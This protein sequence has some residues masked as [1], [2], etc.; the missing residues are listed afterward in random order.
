MKITVLSSLL[1]E[2]FMID[3]GFALDSGILV[4]QLIDHDVRKFS[5][6]ESFTLRYFIP[7]FAENDPS[8]DPDGSSTPPENQ[9]AGI[10][11]MVPLH[12]SMLK[13]GTMCSYGTTEIAEYLRMAL[14]D[15]RVIGVLLD[16]DTPGGSVNSI[17]PL[18]DVL[19]HRTKPVL[20]HVD[21]CASAGLFTSVFCD[22]IMANNDIS[23]RIGSV[24]VEMNFADMRPYWEAQKVVFHTIRPPES[25]EKN[26]VFELALEGKYEQITQEML[27]P[28]ARRFQQEVRSHLPGLKEEPGVLTGATFD[29]TRSLEL[30]LIHS[31]GNRRAAIARL[32]E[33]A[34]QYDVNSLI[35]NP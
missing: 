5:P 3:L 1:R 9:P 4:Q 22:E 26:R 12:G 20:A 19:S 32:S 6:R 24:G 28:M 10:I 15:E 21:S 31:I 34:L 29:A 13:Y 14:S 35:N 17:P 23:A 16:V 27:S 33:L 11:A 30:G 25:A 7:S 8:A 2:P 18:V